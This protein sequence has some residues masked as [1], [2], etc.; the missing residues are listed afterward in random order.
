MNKN[1][2]KP[3][4]DKILAVATRGGEH[5]IPQLADELLEFDS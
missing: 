2:C 3:Q 1:L 4:A 5:E